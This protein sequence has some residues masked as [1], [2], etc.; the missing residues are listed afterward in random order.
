MITRKTH[1]LL[2]F[3]VLIFALKSSQGL[4]QVSDDQCTLDIE[5]CDQNIPDFIRG[6][7]GVTGPQGVQ[8]PVGPRGKDCDCHQSDLRNR[9]LKLEGENKLIWDEIKALIASKND[10]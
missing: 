1:F 7:S 5:T 6:V 3:S 8:G 2:I 4:H 10:Q 9:I